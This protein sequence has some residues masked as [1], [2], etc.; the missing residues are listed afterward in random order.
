MKSIF[1]SLL[2]MSLI[3]TGSLSAKG[4]DPVLM[5]INDQPVL[6]SEFEYI[7]NKNNSNNTLDK[8]SLEEYVDLFVNFKL[9]VEE[10][11]S[12]GLDTTQSFIRELSG[13]RTQLTKPYMTD[14]KVEEAVL[15][16]AFNRLKE[17]V[18]VSHILVRVDPNASPE[19]TLVAWNKI[20]E[21]QKRLAT[22]DFNQVAKEVSE[23]ESA[24][25]N[26]GY[27]G[28]ITGFRTVYPFENAAYATPVGSMSKPIRSPFGYHI[29]KVQDRR[30]SRGEILVSHIM[31]FTAEG[32][33]AKNKVAAERIDSMYKAL[34]AGADF[35]EMA[36]TYSEDRGSASKAGELPWFGIGRMVQEF[37]K[38]AF[39]LKEI[40]DF[41][42]PVQSAYGWHIIKLLDRKALPG[43]ESRKADI[44]RQVKRDERSRMPQKAFVA[45]LKKEYKFK[46]PSKKLVEVYYNLLENHTLADSAFQAEAALLKKPMF[47]FAK[48]KLT[49]ADF[50]AYLKQNAHSSKTSAKDI[51]DEKIDAFVEKELLAYENA[52]LENKYSDF[53]L[54]MQ[55]YHDGILLFEV[56]N[57]EVWEKASRD[58]AG[59]A[60]FFRKNKEKY[61]WDK[62]RFKG[63]V[64]QCKSE[65]VYEKAKLIVASQPKDS[66]DKHL[67]QLN[68]SVIHVKIDKGLFVQGD[69]KQVD[70]HSFKTGVQPE[71]DKN[72]PYVFVSGTMLNY[73]PEEYSD[74]RGLV[75]ADYQEYLE[76]KWIEDLRKKYVVKIDEKVLKT[77]QKN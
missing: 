26:S 11:K 29:V 34:K 3:I 60:N 31:L 1:R 51:I 35:A 46:M 44:E 64:V 75:T 77:I 72:Y 24:R 25:E 61:S 62:P 50:S 16:E 66:I 28:W 2:V 47:R 21:I 10:A 58:T 36:T 73:T 27:I 67:R 6:K 65:E 22:E 53:R 45:Q 42:E 23:D 74:V 68:D 19:D 39:A 55:E 38:A 49:Q 7:Y 43:F 18:E 12:Q 59:L 63:R 41:S 17:D 32:D 56:S 40:G 15:M 48:Q 8:K 33:E 30:E 20:N 76:Q 52:Q 14:Q 69:N 5:Y 54:L 57:N 71:L 37:E 70:F 13:Y 9:K 4:K